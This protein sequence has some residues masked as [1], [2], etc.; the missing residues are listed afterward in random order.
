MITI[1]NHIPVIPRQLQEAPRDYEGACECH[2][3]AHE[4]II[5]FNP[6][7]LSGKEKLQLA[8]MYNVMVKEHDAYFLIGISMSDI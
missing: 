5:A 7:H 4:T 3:I 1:E 8:S 2:S 6:N